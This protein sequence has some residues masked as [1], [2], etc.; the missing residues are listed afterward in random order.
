MFLLSNLLLALPAIA[1]VVAVSAAS[2]DHNT[3]LL[4]D[5]DKRQSA[6]REGTGMSNGFYYSFWNE[7]SGGS[8]SMND[9]PGGRYSTKWNNIGNFV[10]GKGWKPGSAR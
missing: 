4:N 6:L 10:A 9:G 8:V 2:V 3:T 5:F 1:S 7:K